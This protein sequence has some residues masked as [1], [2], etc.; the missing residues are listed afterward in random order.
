[1]PNIIDEFARECLAI[2]INRKLNSTDVIDVLSDLFILR[3][4]PG[5]VLSDNGPEFIAKAVQDCVT[6]VGAKTGYIEP[7]SPWENGYW[8]LLSTRYF[9]RDRRPEKLCL[10]FG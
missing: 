10:V 8:A 1:M 4:V 5:Q 7:A 2:R 3:G 6:L 9:C